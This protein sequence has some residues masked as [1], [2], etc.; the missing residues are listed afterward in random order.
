MNG[1]LYWLIVVLILGSI[2][3]GA[4]T[5]PAPAPT[6]APAATP[7]AQASLTPIPVPSSTPRPAPK[8][9]ATAPGG[10]PAG[11]YRPA[12]KLVSDQIEFDADGSY[13]IMIGSHGIPGTYAVNGDQIVLTESSG[14]CLGYPGTY[15]WE[16]TGKVLTFKTIK[17]TCTATGSQ[18]QPDLSGRAWDLWP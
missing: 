7:T 18:R 1:K 14:I 5:A 10:F 4:C 15:T 8:P 12:Q 11:V 9:T 13:M 17:D 3:M 6:S 2:V 16:I